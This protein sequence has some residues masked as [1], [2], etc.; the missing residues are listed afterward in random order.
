MIQKRKNSTEEEIVKHLVFE[1]ELKEGDDTF[2]ES[3]EEVEES[4]LSEN[5]T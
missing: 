1:E 5:Q 4:Q 3:I 2:Y